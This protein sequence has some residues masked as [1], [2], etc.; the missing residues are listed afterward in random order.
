MQNL[1]VRYRTQSSPCWMLWQALGE[2]WW[3]SV[4]TGSLKTSWP[5]VESK[6]LAAL[7]PKVSQVKNM[8]RPAQGDVCTV[9][10]IT[11]SKQ[12][13]I[14]SKLFFYVLTKHNI[15]WSTIIFALMPMAEPEFLLH[16]TILTWRAGGDDVTGHWNAW[17]AAT[18]CGFSIWDRQTKS[19]SIR[20]FQQLYCQKQNGNTLFLVLCVCAFFFSTFKSLELST[21]PCEQILMYTDT[22]LC[23]LVW[24]LSVGATLLYLQD[25]SWLQSWWKVLGRYQSPLPRINVG[26]SAAHST[27]RPPTHTNIDSGGGGHHHGYPQ[28]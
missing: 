21:F 15:L 2:S 25:Y 9:T 8:T 6:W 16:H 20:S 24:F 28:C 19:V 10:S 17:S 14:R 22:S 3:A 27:W 7:C 18:M 12:C 26:I 4:T 13:L 11:A 1:S 5:E 23:F